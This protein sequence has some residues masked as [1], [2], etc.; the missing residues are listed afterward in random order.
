M[1]AP[2]YYILT[3]GMYVA[4]VE[5]TDVEPGF[6]GARRFDYTVIPDP[7]NTQI[8][9]VHCGPGHVELHHIGAD[10]VYVYIPHLGSC[11]HYPRTADVHLQLISKF[12]KEYQA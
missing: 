6:A 9:I 3:G 4:Y 1:R 8:A 5:A 12:F 10:G 11:W 7:I 2:I